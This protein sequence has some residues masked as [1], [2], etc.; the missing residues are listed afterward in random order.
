MR[1]LF[2]LSISTTRMGNQAERAIE[3]Y[4]RKLIYSES[5]R[6]NSAQNAIASHESSEPESEGRSGHSVAIP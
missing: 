1:F 3:G 6:L 4:Q 5:L 2:A